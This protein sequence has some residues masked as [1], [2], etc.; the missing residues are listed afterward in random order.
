MKIDID[1]NSRYSECNLCG[2]SKIFKINSIIY[3]KPTH[4]SSNEIVISKQPE[5]WKCNNCRSLFV[6]NAV[7]EIDSIKLYS[8]GKSS[9]RWSSN[10]SFE[11]QKSKNIVNILGSILKNKINVLDIGCNT[12]ELLDFAQRQGCKTFGVEYS[13]TSLEL[14]KSKGHIAFSNSDEIESRLFDVITAFDLIEHL[15]D[16][17]SFLNDCYNRLSLGGYLVLLTGNIHSLS[18]FLL[19]S[20]WWYVKYPEHIVFPSRKYFESHTRFQVVNWLRVYHSRSFEYP[21]ISTMKF[22][23]SCLIKQQIYS[24]IPSFQPDHVLIVLRRKN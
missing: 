16:I 1:N 24:G 17:P 18:S 7:Q 9:E 2:S 13:R 14:T 3:N 5:L 22:V 20:N 11:E 8:E 19:G 23:L 15:Y 12:G 10:S 21:I 6:Q 4:Y